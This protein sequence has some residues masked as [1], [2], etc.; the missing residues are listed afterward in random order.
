MAV[1]FSRTIIMFL[2][3]MVLMRIMGKRQ[4][5]ELQINELVV[6]VLTADLAAIPMQDIGIPLINGIVPIVVLFACELII[7]DLGM[8]S[9]R[10]RSLVCGKPCLLIKNGKILQRHMRRCRFTIDDLAEELRS[11][12][13]TDI[14]RVQFAILET[15][16]TLSTVLY[17]TETPVTPSQ[18]GLEVQPLGFPYTIIDSGR[19]LSNNLKLSGHNEAWLQKQL[20]AHGVQ[21]A[22][23]VYALIVFESGKVYF[24]KLEDVK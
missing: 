11:K 23:S 7:S 16:G 3:L 12:S 20:A 6:S 17:P 2:V 18:M 5:G 21:S 19:V 10:F 4:L 1:V 14:S 9:I 22:R 15:D 13:I 24:E 8:R